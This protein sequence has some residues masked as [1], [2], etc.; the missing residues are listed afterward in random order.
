MKRERYMS[1]N[2]MLD[3][4]KVAI[5]AGEAEAIAAR[6]PEKDWRKK[7]NCIATYA[8]KIVD[9]RLAAVDTKQLPALAR[10]KDHSEFV[11]LTSDQRRL[12]KHQD[13]KPEAAIN[14][15]TDDLYDVVDMALLSC[16]KCPQGECVAGCRMRGVYHNLGVPPI[17]TDP[18]T[19][20]C[21][22]RLDNEIQCI[23]PQ[24]QK[25]SDRV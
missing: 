25:I 11:M 18:Q 22:F 14:V 2:E 9:E 3:W 16:M 8:T 20:E 7:L 24:Y 1:K 13:G 21:E 12:N 17:R 10:R 23:T 5:L 19:G 6:T 15:A 4:I